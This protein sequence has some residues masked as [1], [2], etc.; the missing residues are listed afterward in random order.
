MSEPTTRNFA[1]TA[2]W[3]LPAPNTCVELPHKFRAEKPSLSSKGSEYGFGY[4]RFEACACYATLEIKDPSLGVLMRRLAK[5]HPTRDLCLGPI[6]TW[7]LPYDDC[8]V[9]S[10]VWVGI[11]DTCTQCTMPATSLLHSRQ[12]LTGIH[13][14]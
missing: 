14:S 10:W 2:R 1:D 8:E 11:W 13:L 4:N 7:T 5:D 12:P 9:F 6:A 3:Y